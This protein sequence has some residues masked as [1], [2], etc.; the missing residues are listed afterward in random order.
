MMNVLLSFLLMSRLLIASLVEIPPQP[1][2]R[3][4]LGRWQLQQ[5]RFG[6]AHDHLFFDRSQPQVSALPELAELTIQLEA[7]GHLWLSTPSGPK[8]GHWQYDPTTRRIRLGLDTPAELTHVQLA[9]N[10]LTVESVDWLPFL[11]TG[12]Y[13][14]TR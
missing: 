11:K 10:R 4:L 1:D 13:I 6:P 5:V 8:P 7:G 14:L 3:S 2:V 12:Q 9:G